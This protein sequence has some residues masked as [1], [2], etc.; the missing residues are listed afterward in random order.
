MCTST[1]NA[2]TRHTNLGDVCA[3]VHGIAIKRTFTTCLHTPFTEVPERGAIWQPFA[4]GRNKQTATAGVTRTTIGV[5]K[6]TNHKTKLDS[7]KGYFT[8]CVQDLAVIRGWETFVCMEIK[9]HTHTHSKSN[10]DSEQSRF[11][12]HSRRANW[13]TSV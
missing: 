9:T 8:K 11:T 6:K 10:D 7:L 5:E 3:T 12:R 2:S 13:E 4:R 1:V